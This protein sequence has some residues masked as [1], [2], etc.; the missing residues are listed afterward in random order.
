M[1]VFDEIV[2]TATE[3]DIVKDCLSNPAVVKYLK[4]LASSASH[5]LVMSFNTIADSNELYAAKA[6]FVNGQVSTIDQL[7]SLVDVV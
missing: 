1:R 6:R 3:I 4:G 7:L 5:D 2:M